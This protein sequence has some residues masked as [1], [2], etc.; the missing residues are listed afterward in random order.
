MEIFFGNFVQILE[1]FEEILDK[2]ER[3]R[4]FGKTYRKSKEIFSKFKV[5]LRN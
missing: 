5:N 3:Q 2:Y 1:I 4:S